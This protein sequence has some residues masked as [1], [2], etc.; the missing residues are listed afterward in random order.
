[1]A[2]QLF[3]RALAAHQ[4]TRHYFEISHPGTVVLAGMRGEA[5]TGMRSRTT[6]A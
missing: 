1:M 3:K 2:S 6:Q 5:L 4:P